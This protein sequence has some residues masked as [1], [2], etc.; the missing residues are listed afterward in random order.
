MTKHIQ[1]KQVPGGEPPI[2]VEVRIL[3]VRPREGRSLILNII[4]ISGVAIVAKTKTKFP[5]VFKMMRQFFKPGIVW[6]KDV[7]VLDG[8][9]ND[10]R[11]SLKIFWFVKRIILTQHKCVTLIKG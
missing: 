7:V 4:I 9:T 8:T 10:R 6:K 11:R 1:S 3:E 2:N 5:I